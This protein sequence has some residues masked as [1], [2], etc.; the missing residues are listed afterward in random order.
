MELREDFCAGYSSLL[1]GHQWFYQN[2]TRFE[3]MKHS[4]IKTSDSSSALELSVSRGL[5]GAEACRMILPGMEREK[6]EREEWGKEVRRGKRRK[7][8]IRL[9]SAADV[10][11][12]RQQM[13]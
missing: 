12:T 6:R 10:D 5:K 3:I 8:G 13:G 11:T 9:I 7:K 4:S 2:S 1:S